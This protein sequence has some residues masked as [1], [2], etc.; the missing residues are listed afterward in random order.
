MSHYKKNI[1]LLKSIQRKATKMIK[2]LEEKGDEDKL[3]PH[4]LF[5]FFFFSNPEERPGGNLIAVYSSLMRGSGG[6]GAELFSES[7]RTQFIL[8]IRD[9]LLS[10]RGNGHWNRLPREAVTAPRSTWALPSYVLYEF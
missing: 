3:K 4:F 8:D 10:N 7:N 6:T 1:K 5:F 2:G 9:T